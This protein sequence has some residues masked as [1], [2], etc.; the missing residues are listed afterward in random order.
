MKKILSQIGLF[1]FIGMIVLNM[2][3]YKSCT[4][5]KE[6]YNS[7]HKRVASLYQKVDSILSLPP[8]TITLPAEIIKE[9]TIVYI[10]RW[11]ERP[12][13]TELKP[14]IYNDSILNDSIDLRVEIA[15]MEL[16]D[17]KY[18]YSPIYKY[19]TRVIKQY[20]PKPFDVIKE[21]KVPQNGLY[22]NVGLGYSDRFV[23]KVGLMYLTKRQN[24]FG[25]DFIRHGNTS[26][27]MGVYGIKL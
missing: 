21:I 18:D 8:D 3:T 6:K 24:T 12:I 15:A 10:T 23:G 9:D 1:V 27:H 25:Y 2:I 16:F 13:D 7:E 19:Q 14:Q 17:I 20:V 22:F 26:I 4:N 11:K 5:Y